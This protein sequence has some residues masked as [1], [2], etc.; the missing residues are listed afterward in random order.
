MRKRNDAGKSCCGDD[1]KCKFVYKQE[2]NLI[3]IT[4]LYCKQWT[5]NAQKM[6]RGD[7]DSSFFQCNGLKS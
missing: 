4:E 5:T 3:L 1:G 6:I 2:S 7:D